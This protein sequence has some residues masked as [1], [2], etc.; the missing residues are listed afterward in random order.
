MKINVNQTKRIKFR[1]SGRLAVD[2][3]FYISKREVEF[4]NT[5]CY[6]GVI[7][8]HVIPSYHLKHQV[9]KT[10]QSVASISQKLNLQNVNFNSAQKLFN[11]FCS[12]LNFRNRDIR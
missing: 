12:S 10:Y 8:K 7:F 3:K 2:E 11:S 1:R 5:F 9:N 4:T 6:L